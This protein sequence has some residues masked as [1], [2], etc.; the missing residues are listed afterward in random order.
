MIKRIN[1]SFQG[2]T[3][4]QPKTRSPIKKDICLRTKHPTVVGVE[5]FK[6]FFKNT[7]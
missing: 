5:R 3:L 7:H 6:V 4:Y 1:A 2:H